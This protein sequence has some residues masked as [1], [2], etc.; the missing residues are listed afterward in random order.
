MTT[1][2]RVRVDAA[3]SSLR[4]GLPI[5]LSHQTR[6]DE[7]EGYLVLPADRATTEITSFLV[8]H[9]SG[10]VCAAVPAADCER[11]WLPPM[12]GTRGETGFTVTLDAIEGTTTGI[13]ASDR[14][15]TLRRMA[16]PLSTAQDFTRP[17]HV[18]PVRVLEH[19]RRRGESTVADAASDLCQA[20]GG[21]PIAAFAALVSEIDETLL[22][23]EIECHMFATRHGLNEVTIADVAHYCRT[24]L[25]YLEKV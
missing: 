14:A 4:S 23:G 10:L 1:E 19:G 22:A 7:I 5:V 9:T 17:G 24:S 21:S 8:R 18:S 13:S 16:N 6:F 25:N 11:L 3:I 2:T 20:V 12:S 15:T